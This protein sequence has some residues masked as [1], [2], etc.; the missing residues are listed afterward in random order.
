MWVGKVKR[1][2]Q[3]AATRITMCPFKVSYFANLT[4]PMF[5][6]NNMLPLSVS[7][8]KTQSL[9]LLFTPRLENVF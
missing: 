3:T 5:S 4:S 6:V 8:L 1:I 2:F 9:L 7:E